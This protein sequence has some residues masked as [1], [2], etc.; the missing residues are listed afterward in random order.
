MGIPPF[1]PPCPRMRRPQDAS[2]EDARKDA[3]R[4]DAGHQSVYKK[5]T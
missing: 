1:P 2:R 5:N 4:E 3:G